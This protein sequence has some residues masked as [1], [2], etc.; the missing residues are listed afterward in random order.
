MKIL[1]PKLIAGYKTLFECIV[2]NEYTDA[3]ICG[4]CI[5]QAHDGARCVGG[6]PPGLRS[7]GAP[8]ELHSR[9]LVRVDEGAGRVPEVPGPERDRVH[10][11]L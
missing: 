11:V 9:G 8:R 3:K 7:S 10:G 2:A 5:E 6:S 1:T 4:M